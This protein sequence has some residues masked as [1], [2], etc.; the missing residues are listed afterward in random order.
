MH[1]ATIAAPTLVESSQIFILTVCASKHQGRVEVAVLH[2][3]STCGL[4]AV[5]VGAM[6]SAR[7]RAIVDA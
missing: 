4:L 7:R 3:C 6:S 1:D 2:V 5:I